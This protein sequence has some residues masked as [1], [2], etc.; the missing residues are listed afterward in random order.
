MKKKLLLALTLIIL[1]VSVVC[2]L[3]FLFIKK[4][5]RQTQQKTL[6][7]LKGLPY[8]TWVPSE[9]T[10]EKQGVTEYNK[11][12]SFKGINIYNSRNLSVA[13]LFNMSGDILH[14]W[15][16]PEDT[17]ASWMHIEMCSNGDLLAIIENS[18]L[19]RLDWASNILWR[20]QGR[21]HHDIDKAENGDIYSITREYVKISQVDR[22]KKIVDDHIVI[23]SANG[24]LK[25]K[26][27]L[28]TI[29]LKKRKYLRTIKKWRYWR[30]MKELKDNDVFHTNTL[31]IIKKD[32]DF[33]SH[34]LFWKGLVLICC[35]HLGVVAVLD[36][37]NEKVAWEWG[38][39]VLD[40]PHH[41]TILDNGNILI[42]DNGS[43]RG[44][45]RIIELNPLTKGIEW[46]YEADPPEEFFSFSRGSNQELPNG[47]ILIAE[48]DRGRVFEIT[49]DGKVVWEFYNPVIREDKKERAA[50]Y[51][52]MRLY[53]FNQ[54]PVLK[55][56]K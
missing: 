42:F 19:V 52:M 28:A 10:L 6:E 8:L 32:V 13:H 48:S 26:I 41:P 55:S 27:S 37:K 3:Y 5:D 30:R 21:Y 47:N 15:A 53:D 38:T 16:M 31:E 43:E 36:L 39:D 45:S 46:E 22:E 7:A 35:R 33:G 24:D 14:S 44:Y 11:R 1:V 34:K 51:R 2:L 40:N 29:L 20:D 56:L 17:K 50:I 25:E 23:L 18:E 12:K 54:F 4:E 9:Q 49:K